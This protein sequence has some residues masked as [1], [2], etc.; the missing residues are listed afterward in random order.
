MAK[1]DPLRRFLAGSGLD[2]VE[3]G[4]EQIAA[5]VPGGLPP[6]AYD[7]QRRMWWAITSGG[8]MSRRR[9]G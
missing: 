6:S 2:V 1:Y 7:R 9:R 8:S 3:L 4:F 5:M